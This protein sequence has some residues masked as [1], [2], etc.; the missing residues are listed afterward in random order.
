MLPLK[1]FEIRKHGNK[2]S[3]D[4]RK[5]INTQAFIILSTKSVLY[6]S[7]Q[8]MSLCVL[9]SCILIIVLLLRMVPTTV[10][11]HT[12]CASRDTRVSYW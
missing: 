9:F 7:R 5:N 8:L 6:S 1:S 11:A 2:I 10:I 12:F 3:S 4:L